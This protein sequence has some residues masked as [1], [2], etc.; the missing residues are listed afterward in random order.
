MIIGP[1]LLKNSVL[2]KKTRIFLCGPG[3]GGVNFSIREF[4]REQLASIPNVSVHYG[5]EIEKLATFKRRKHDLQT[6]EVEFAHA[7]DF[8]LLILESPGSIAELG[9]FS[10]MKNLRGRLVV[11]VPSQF[12]RDSSYIARGPLSLISKSHLSNV[13]YFDRDQQAPLKQRILYPL[14]FYKFAHDRLSNKYQNH[15]NSAY[16]DREYSENSYE[17]FISDTRNEFYVSITYA[18]ILMLGRPTFPELISSTSLSADST[19]TALHALYQ[20]GKVTKLSNG[21]YKPLT[22]FGDDLLSS[23]STTKISEARAKFIA[24]L[25]DGI[26][27]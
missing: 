2:K 21:R 7:S 27:R 13:I 8:T 18:A 20:T 1:E 4:A 3:I 11:L 12:Y 24:Q 16:K 5:E 17:T 23:F 14:T 15:I 22:S 25:D 9:T 19:S 6:L 10:M 26:T